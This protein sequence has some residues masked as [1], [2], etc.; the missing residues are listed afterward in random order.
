MHTLS[1]QDEAGKTCTGSIIVPTLT[2]NPPQT[3]KRT[4]PPITPL[5]P[6]SVI[7][8]LGCLPGLFPSVHGTT[9]YWY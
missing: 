5:P 9:P 8:N 1:E 2:L 6:L 4:P 3:N 7:E